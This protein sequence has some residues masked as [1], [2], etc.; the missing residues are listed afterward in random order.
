[1]TKLF[2]SSNNPGSNS[3]LAA[4]SKSITISATSTLTAN[5]GEYDFVFLASE[6]GLIC[7]LNSD[8]A[9]L[10]RLYNS[11]TARDLDLRAYDEPPITSIDGLL[12]EA[13]LDQNGKLNIL[14]AYGSTTSFLYGKLFNLELI[15]S[16]PEVSLSLIKFE[17]QT[18]NKKWFG[19]VNVLKI[20]SNIDI[21]IVC[22][23]AFSL[24]GLYG[25]T[26]KS[27]TVSL[28]TKINGVAVEELSNI[29]VNSS[30]QNINS[31]SPL[32]LMAGDII[33]FSLIYQG[34]TAFGLRFSVKTILD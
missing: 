29:L 7:E 15:D 10:L 21:D 17:A 32:Q 1:M 16:Q 22:P 30:A 4:I 6:L 9:I 13:E 19:S 33:T 23:Q 8:S 5:G 25:L 27:G 11:E 26:T 12:L 20:F 31:S 24:E 3:P 28:S 34:S 2:Y 14:Q 18:L